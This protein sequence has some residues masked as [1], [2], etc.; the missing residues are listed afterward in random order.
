MAYVKV[1]RSLAQDHHREI[2]KALAA[3][4]VDR[5]NE[6][7]GRHRQETLEK[8]REIHRRNTQSDS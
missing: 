4:D 6:W 2:M 3:R 8:V 7:M 5:V 1:P